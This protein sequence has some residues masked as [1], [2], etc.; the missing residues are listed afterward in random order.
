MVTAFLITGVWY[1]VTRAAK[2]VVEIYIPA[3]PPVPAIP[4]GIPGENP[5]VPAG[6][7]NSP[8]GGRLNPKFIA[9]I[10]F[11]NLL[12]LLIIAL[13]AYY[14]NLSMVKKILFQL[15]YVYYTV[16]VIGLGLLIS[17]FTLSPSEQPAAF[18]STLTL[19]ILCILT[20]VAIMRNSA[21]LKKEDVEQD[22]LNDLRKTLFI[23]EGQKG[24]DAKRIEYEYK[25]R[26]ADP[27][28][29]MEFLTDTAYT[30]WN[31]FKRTANRVAS[32]ISKN[33]ELEQ[34]SEAVTRKTRFLRPG[35]TPRE[36]ER[37]YKKYYDSFANLSKAQRL[38]LYTNEPEKPVAAHAVNAAQSI[39]PGKAAAAGVLMAIAS[40][41]P[42]SLL[43][44][45]AAV[46][47]SAAS[48]VTAAAAPHVVLFIII[49]SVIFGSRDRARRLA[50]YYFNFAEATVEFTHD[51]AEVIAEKLKGVADFKDAKLEP[52][53]PAP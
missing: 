48:S 50:T 33:P 11:G 9:L 16:I 14:M 7:N 24:E 32:K 19:G 18:Y 37:A 21:K 47:T 34:E 41:L 36:V 45:T 17:A 43:S 2:T 39:T 23:D 51:E 29:S 3:D 25:E 38:M 31:F 5:L 6:P 20:S 12:L 42:V 44:M 27:A 26:V 30:G 13:I 53:R 22:A 8:A 28:T 35:I 49:G 1:G 4:G 52:S 10:V 15:K 40:I 46:A